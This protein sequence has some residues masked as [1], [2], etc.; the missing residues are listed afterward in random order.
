MAKVVECK[1]YGRAV[2]KIVVNASKVY[3]RDEYR[4]LV[5]TG[6]CRICMEAQARGLL[7]V[8]TDG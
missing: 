8:L 1:G 7:R 5:K 2:H 4:N 3:S 6:Y